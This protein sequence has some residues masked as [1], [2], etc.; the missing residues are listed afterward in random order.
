MI[1]LLKNLLFVVLVPGT[2]AAL[3][4]WRLA[5]GRTPVG[6]AHAVVAAALW[7]AGGALLLACVWQFAAFGRGTPAPIDAPRRLV[8][9][10]AYRFVRNPMYL[11][12]LAAI[13]GW[14]AWYG[15][16]RLLLYAF[17]VG[18]AF[19]LFVLLYEEPHLAHE[20]GDSYDDYRAHVRRWLPR[21]L[22]WPPRAG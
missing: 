3:L 17:A 2:V 4:P 10:G 15:D 14:A 8:V 20:F 21:R 12:V 1:L 16:A 19:H 9:R 11:G 7:I 22:G 5:V 6:G 18:V 13:L